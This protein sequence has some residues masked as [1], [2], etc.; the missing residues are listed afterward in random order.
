MTIED[1]LR[2][3]MVKKSGSVNKFAS[4]CGVPYS[5]IASIFRRGVIN[6]NINT[7]IKICQALQISADELSNGRITYL[8]EVAH[9]LIE[10]EKLSKDN[11]TRLLA[12][13]QALLDSQEDK[14]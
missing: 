13:Y 5:T 6:T 3:L 14:A 11:Q 7:I 2:G 9:P 12:Y 4:E 8:A 10:F 1:E